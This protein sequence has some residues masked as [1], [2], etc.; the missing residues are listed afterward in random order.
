MHGDF[1][2]LR[3][4][5]DHEDVARAMKQH[6]FLALPVVGPRMML[7]GVV[8]ADDVADVSE[9]E[10]TEDIQQLGGTSALDAP[11]LH[12]NMLSMLRKRGGWLTLLFLG[13]T[14]TATVM[15]HFQTHIAQ[16]VVLA[17][18]IP[19]IVSSGGNSGSQSA[20]LIVRSLALAELRLRDWWRVLGREV[21]TGLALGA[22]LGLIGFARVVAWQQFGWADYGPHHMLIGFTVGVSLAGVVLFGCVVGSTFPFLLRAAGFDPATS[23]SPF[24]ATFVDVAGL[25]IYFTVA[26]QLLRG[27]MFAG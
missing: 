8:T 10:A 23:S 25:I 22:W 6:R 20:T 26:A 5:M 2:T 24:V 14:L 19:L 16:A 1:I 12:V 18:F 9:E 17:L 27:T 21:R 15:G 13:E 7:L 4:E 11:Y 3:A